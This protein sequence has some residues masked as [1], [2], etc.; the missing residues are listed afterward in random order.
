ML[1]A[2]WP[3]E[4]SIAAALIEPVEPLVVTEIFEEIARSE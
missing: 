3:D 2:G 1:D 4:R